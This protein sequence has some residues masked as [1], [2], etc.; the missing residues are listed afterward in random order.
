MKYALEVSLQDYKQKS[1]DFLKLLLNEF[2]SLHLV[3]SFHNSDLLISIVMGSIVRFFIF[4]NS[5]PSIL[6]C[7]NKFT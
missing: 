1:I 3:R 2:P 4:Y 7:I 5:K 6:N